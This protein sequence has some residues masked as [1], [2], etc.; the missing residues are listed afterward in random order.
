MAG[1]KRSSA[2][3]VRSALATQIAA[4]RGKAGAEVALDRF[5]SELE[6]ATRYDI[7]TALKELE[8]TGV[9]QFVVG[10]SGRKSR[11]IWGELAESVPSVS[12]RPVPA[13]P[14]PPAAPPSVERE[15][16]KA[17]ADRAPTHRPE[18]PGP[19]GSVR[20]LEHAFYVRTGVLAKVQLPD[21]VTRPEIERL[22]QLLRAIPF[23]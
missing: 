8:K 14:A 2:K 12:A 4:R 16:R 13:R 7:V 6:G 15:V 23:E 22:C 18:A 1:K 17:A 11:F 20:L 9:G 10:R 19:V 5:E 21:D 3:P